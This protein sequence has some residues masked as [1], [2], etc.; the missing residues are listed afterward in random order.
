MDSSHLNNVLNN[1]RVL[2]KDDNQLNELERVII[3]YCLNNKIVSFDTFDTNLITQTANV[4]LKSIKVSSKM[5]V[6]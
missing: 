4:K 2:A 3:N 5:N 1:L 6:K